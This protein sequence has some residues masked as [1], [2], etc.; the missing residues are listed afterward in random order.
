[1][2]MLQLMNVL[3]KIG[4]LVC[5]H[6]MVVGSWQ[7]VW[8]WPETKAGNTSQYMFRQEMTPLDSQCTE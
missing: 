7:A 3:P 1:M 8:M 4:S 5:D 6:A 2:Q